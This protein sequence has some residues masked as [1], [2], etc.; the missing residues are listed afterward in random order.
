MYRH[1]VIRTGAGLA[2]ILAV[3]LFATGCATKYATEA[4]MQS[5]EVQKQAALS[6]EQKV[7]DLEATRADYAKQ[8]A[9]RNAELQEVQAERT[10]VRQRLTQEG[11]KRVP[12]GSE[13][14]TPVP[15]K[16]EQM[17]AP[18]T[19]EEMMPE[20][21]QLEETAPADTT[22]APEQAPELEQEQPGELEEQPQEEEKEQ[23]EDLFGYVSFRGVGQ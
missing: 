7:Q 4:D 20:M 14:Q 8:V 3:G 12:L 22:I 11:E 9:D 16:K 21:E 2:A 13:E 10:A 18:D 19:T 15:P 1:R 5:L 23:T 6:A 17:A